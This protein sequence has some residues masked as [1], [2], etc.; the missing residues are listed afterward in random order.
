[1]RVLRSNSRTAG[2]L[3]L[4]GLLLACGSEQVRPDVGRAVSG[5]P[6]RVLISEVEADPPGADDCY[7]YVELLG[8]AGADLSGLILVAL[9]ADLSSASPGIV[10]WTADL[11]TACDGRVC[12]LG[13]NGLFLLR[14]PGGHSS[15][16]PDTVVAE[17]PVLQGGGLENGSL[18]LLLVHAG[19]PPKVQEDWDSNDDCALDLPQ[20][21]VVL[22]AVGWLD[23]DPGDCPYPGT[24]LTAQRPSAAS[25]FDGETCAACTQ[26]WLPGTLDGSADSLAFANGWTL[27]P[28]GP[29]PARLAAGAPQVT[30]A[31]GSSSPASVDPSAALA[32]RGGAGPAGGDSGAAMDAVVS[33]AGF[34]HWRSPPVVVALGEGQGG[35]AGAFPQTESGA[36]LPKTPGSCECRATGL[37][38]RP[39]SRWWWV[40]VAVLAAVARWTR[41]RHAAVARR[42]DIGYR[43]AGLGREVCRIELSGMSAS[44]TSGSESH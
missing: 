24:L 8:P 26:A 22:D 36:E 2:W 15:V 4:S 18:A 39:T 38:A 27:T 12:S 5:L 40:C 20:G 11:Q 42:M 9:D 17:D 43:R 31:A 19:L 28:G 13:R 16:A 10:D 1:M 29:N 33:A 3:C 7:Q 44:V 21:A 34:G 32:A 23:A 14:A 35:I 37:Y 41:P 6:D 30:A 25:R